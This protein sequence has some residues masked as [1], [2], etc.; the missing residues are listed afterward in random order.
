MLE[1]I[2]LAAGQG[3][4]MQTDFPKVLHTLAGA[5]IISHVV[6]TVRKLHSSK[7]HVV[8]GYKSEMVKA[9]LSAFDIKIVYYLNM[10][11][12]K[13]KSGIPKSMRSC[14]TAHT[15]G[16]FIEGH[17]PTEDIKRLIAERPNA[18]GLAVPGMPFGS[19]GMGPEAERQAYNV[20]IIRRNRT[21]EVFQHYPK[22]GLL[23]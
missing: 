18:L 10:T 17:V 7:I 11:K 14:H 22:A 9:S 15:M 21:P 16:Y 1:V 2:I 6:E 5:T 20:F 12:F 13:I 8:V 23:V 19:P 4:R 3:R